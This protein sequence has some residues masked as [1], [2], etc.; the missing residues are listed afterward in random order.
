[1]YVLKK[2]LPST[3]SRWLDIG[4]ILFLHFYGPR[5]SQETQIKESTK[6]ARNDLR[7]FALRNYSE[8]YRMNKPLSGLLVYGSIIPPAERLPSKFQSCP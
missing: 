3:R 5:Q 8:A 4:Y 7:V 2:L 6:Y 1:M